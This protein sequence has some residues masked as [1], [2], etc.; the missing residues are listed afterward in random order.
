VPPRHR[1]AWLMGFAMLQ[2]LG[3]I[4]FFTWRPLY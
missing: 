1:T 2:G 4:V 3:A